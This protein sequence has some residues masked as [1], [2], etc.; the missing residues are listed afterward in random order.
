[1]VQKWKEI[2]KW[3]IKKYESFVK[4]LVNWYEERQHK[5]FDRAWKLGNF[6]EKC[7]QVEK[8]IQTYTHISK[9]MQ[10]KAYIFK[11]MNKRT[12]I[13]KFFE[14]VLKSMKNLWSTKKML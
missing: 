10:L 5:K 3:V 6:F 9:S 13:C 2:V 14:K 7:A 12:K 4:K 11:R 1:M 8:C